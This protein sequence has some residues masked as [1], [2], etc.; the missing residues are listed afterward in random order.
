MEGAADFLTKARNKPAAPLLAE[1][2]PKLGLHGGIALDLGCGVGAEAELLARYGFMVEALDIS[3]AAVAAA[4]RRCEGLTVEVMQKDFRAHPIEA[5]KYTIA[6]A[7]NSLPFLP[8]EDCRK[9]LGDVQKGIKIGG[10]V[11]LAVYGP[12]HAWAGQRADMSFWSKEEF[13][14]LWDG[15]EP[16]HFEEYMG[17]FPLST[18]EE[19]FQHRIHL[20]ATKNP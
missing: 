11:V 14:N 2:L 9:F 7:I 1:W 6:V 19:I 4:K 16:K 10:A 15:W 5:D 13:G 12:E 17:P 3:E 20:V 8:K 18:G